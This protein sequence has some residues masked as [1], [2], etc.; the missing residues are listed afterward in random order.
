MDVHQHS[1]H[2]SGLRRSGS[3]PRM[4]TNMCMCFCEGTRFKGKPKDNNHFGATR[5]LRQTH[6][7]MMTTH[8]RKQ[9]VRSTGFVRAFHLGLCR[10][11]GYLTR[12]HADSFLKTKQKCS[13]GGVWA[14]EFTSGFHSSVLGRTG[15]RQPSG[16]VNPFASNSQTC[17]RLARG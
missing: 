1:L 8:M 17:R 14:L 9:T 2:P 3:L 4:P 12:S 5:I 11:K 6:M 10:M 13:V 15:N 7:N 16:S